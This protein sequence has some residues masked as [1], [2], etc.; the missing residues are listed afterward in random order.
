ML[1]LAS[2]R[3]RA[4]TR[5]ETALLV[6]ASI[7]LVT[8]LFAIASIGRFWDHYAIQAIV[9]LAPL[10]TMGLRHIRAA[11]QT[12]DKLKTW[13]VGF[14]SLTVAI[15]FVD[16]TWQ[17]F[18]REGAPWR[19]QQREA[20]R[21]AAYLTAHTLPSDRV[22]VYRNWML[23]IY[24]LSER[25]PPTRNFM[26]AQTLDTDPFD[27]R[28]NRDGAKLRAEALLALRSHPPKYFVVGGFNYRVAEIE[29]MISKD[30]HLEAWFGD[31]AAVFDA[32]YRRN[33]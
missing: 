25:F 13:V 4:A 32:L 2:S 5:N 20:E 12:G 23:C 19:A 27:H 17:W 26:D 18:G 29:D 24:Y 28:P 14:L 15:Q 9:P 16:L 22:F 6:G 21:A 1:S 3:C 8:S 30:Y 10:A 33:E 31:P 7:W 11:D